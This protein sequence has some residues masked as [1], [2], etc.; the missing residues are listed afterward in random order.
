MKN[1][2]ILLYQTDRPQEAE[3]PFRVAL[4]LNKQLAAEFPNQAGESDAAV[5]AG[6]AGHRAAALPPAGS[7]STRQMRRCQT[8]V[9]LA[10]GT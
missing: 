6:I 8:Q 4:A 3:E 10:Q 1:L 5:F 9:T 2:G 7:D